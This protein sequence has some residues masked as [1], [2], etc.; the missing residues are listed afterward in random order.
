MTKSN[1]TRGK[2]VMFDISHAC[3]TTKLSALALT[4]DEDDRDIFFHFLQFIDSC[5]IS[6]AA[7]RLWCEDGTADH[8]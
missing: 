2:H 5:R 4:K 8:W 1:V 7:V 3:L 6:T